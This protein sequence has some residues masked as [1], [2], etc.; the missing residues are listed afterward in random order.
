MTVINTL[1]VNSDPGLAPNFPGQGVD[2]VTRRYS[3]QLLAALMGD[4]DGITLAALTVVFAALPTSRPTGAAPALWRD[5]AADNAVK[6]YG[7]EAG[8]DAFILDTNTL[9]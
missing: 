9:G 6:Y 5:P 4:S 2:G 1:P 8:L 3:V 7:G